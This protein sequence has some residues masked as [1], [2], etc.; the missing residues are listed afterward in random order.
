MYVFVILY[1]GPP[2][3]VERASDTNVLVGD[4]AI[5]HCQTSNEPVANY[6]WQKGDLTVSDGSYSRFSFSEPATSDGTLVIANVTYGDRGEYKCTAT[7]IHG[8]VAASAIL[9]VQG[10]LTM[11]IRLCL[12]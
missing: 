7:N 8:V 1:L 9:N 3:F 2:K 11:F 5:F 12:K 6:V 4:T 10:I